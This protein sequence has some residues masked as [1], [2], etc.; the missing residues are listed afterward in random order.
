MLDRLNCAALGFY[1]TSNSP[2]FVR[3][4]L[5]RRHC[6]S[7]CPERVSHISRRLDFR[8]IEH[9]PAPLADRDQPLDAKAHGS[10]IA[11][12]RRRDYGPN[13]G[14]PIVVKKFLGKLR[15]AR[16][17]AFRLSARVPG[18]A[19]LETFSLILS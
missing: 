5:T 14:V 19:L 16:A 1:D 17:G 4:Q 10:R 7:Y 3:G 8:Q 9:D 15:D 18:H 6:P 13:D 2:R 12:L 11:A